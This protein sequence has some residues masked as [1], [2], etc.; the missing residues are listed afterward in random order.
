MSFFLSCFFIFVL[1][2]AATA[3]YFKRHAARFSGGYTPASDVS[4]RNVRKLHR[5]GTGADPELQDDSEG[6][7]A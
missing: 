2:Y 7:N 1:D 4:L 6:G 3:L 5:K